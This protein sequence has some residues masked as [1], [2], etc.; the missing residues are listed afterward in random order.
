[1][2]QTIPGL[3]VAEPP[4]DTRNYSLQ[5]VLYTTVDKTA[6]CHIFFSHLIFVQDISQLQKRL[7]S[8]FSSPVFMPFNSIWKL[9][10]LFISTI[11]T[12]EILSCFSIPWETH[13]HFIVSVGY[14]LE[15]WTSKF[16]LVPKVFP[17]CL[18]CVCS[19]FLQTLTRKNKN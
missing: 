9:A 1:M 11:Q 14:I 16:I 2:C 3:K 19:Y 8:R 10:A 5:L 12:Q 13:H 6:N 7:V 4:A 15:S 17:K 18:C